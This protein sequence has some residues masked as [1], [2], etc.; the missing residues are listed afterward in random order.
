MG[1]KGKLIASMEVKCGGHLVHDIFHI[2]AH[3]IPNISPSKVNHFEIHEDEI[4]KI[5]S[6]VSWKYNHD[7]KEKFAKQVIEAIDPPTK[8]ITWKVIEGDVLQSYNSFI[9][10]TYCDHQWTTVDLKNEKKIE[11]TPE[12][13]TL[14][15]FFIGVIND[16]ESHLLKK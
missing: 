10:I 13:L 5:G 7:G 4:L 8:S 14:L 12:P 2:N 6:I 1:L 3:H 11:D 9:V 15:D 16:I